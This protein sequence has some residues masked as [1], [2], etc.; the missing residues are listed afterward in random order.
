MLTTDVNV[1]PWSRK[2]PSSDTTLASEI[3]QCAV[4]AY[5]DECKRTTF[6]PV[7]EGGRGENSKVD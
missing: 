4:A 7:I 3:S 5:C 6:I 2:V 1:G